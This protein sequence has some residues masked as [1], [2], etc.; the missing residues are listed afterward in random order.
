MSAPRDQRIVVAPSLLAAD[1]GRLCEEVRAV[2]AAGADWLHLDIMDGHFVPNLSFGPTVLKA[3]RPHTRLPFD[4]HLMIAPAD[5]Y[6]AAFAE[7][8][9]DGITVHAEAGPHLDRSLQ[10]IRGLGKRAG[11]SICPATPAVLL[12]DVLDRLDLILV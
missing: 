12:E 9:C 2:E 3:L 6:L 1:F 7:A 5:P 8:G 10:A 11:V 4:C